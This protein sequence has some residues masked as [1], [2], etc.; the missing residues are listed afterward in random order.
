M[1]SVLVGLM[2]CCVALLR[3]CRQWWNMMPLDCMGLGAMHRGEE[4]R[5][6]VASL[7]CAI[8]YMSK[9]GVRLN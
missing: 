6:N 2:I 7:L 1:D 5:I 4:G 8:L 3:C 9:L